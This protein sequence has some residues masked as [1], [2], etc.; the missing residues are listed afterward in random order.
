[1][2]IFLACRGFQWGGPVRRQIGHRFCYNMGFS[3]L[4]VRTLDTINLNYVSFCMCARGI[5]MHG[6]IKHQWTK[7]SYGWS[8]DA[9][10]WLFNSPNKS[11]AFILADNG[12][13]VW[14]GNNRGTISS[15]GHTSLSAN[16]LVLFVLTKC[17]L[18]YMNLIEILCNF[19]SLLTI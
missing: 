1:M 9:A 2:V 7:T 12:F 5:F 13:D 11:L 15:R 10:T 19:W 4:G 6:R 3:W 18:H 16:D 8:Q 14:M 17:R